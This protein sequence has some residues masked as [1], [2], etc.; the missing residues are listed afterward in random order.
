MKNNL[1][2]PAPPY[3]PPLRGCSCSSISLV[4]GFRVF[5]CCCPMRRTRDRGGLWRWRGGRKKEQIRRWNIYQVLFHFVCL[6]VYLF[7]CWWNIISKKSAFKVFSFTMVR[8]R[9]KFSSMKYSGLFSVVCYRNS[10]FFSLSLQAKTQNT[11]TK[12]IKIRGLRN[13]LWTIK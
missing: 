2:T 10:F 4:I 7:I 12:M 11:K 5:T 13:F 1:Y 6:F 8:D 3:F 9:E